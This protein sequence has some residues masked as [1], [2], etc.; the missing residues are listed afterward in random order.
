MVLNRDLP[1][2][3]AVALL[4]ATHLGTLAG[5]EIRARAATSTRQQDVGVV[6][7]DHD[8]DEATGLLERKL[9]ARPVTRGIR[10]DGSEVR[11]HQ[12]S[13]VGATGGEGKGT[14]ARERDRTQPA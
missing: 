7:H 14:G 12:N 3:D 4:V 1:G 10:G 6:V 13:T 11:E 5:L 9:P 2:G 8:D